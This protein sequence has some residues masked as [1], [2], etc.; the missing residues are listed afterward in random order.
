MASGKPVIAVNEGG[1]LETVTP[2]TGVLVAPSQVNIVNAIK[3][4]SRNPESYKEACVAR[5]REFNPARFEERIKKAVENAY[6]A[7]QRTL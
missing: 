5:A 4:L 7:H 2:Q 3:T 1:F 6:S